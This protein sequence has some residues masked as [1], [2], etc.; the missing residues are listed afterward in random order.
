MIKQLV[1]NLERLN[2]KYEREDKL[3]RTV[4][5]LFSQEGNSYSITI[6]QNNTV[7][8]NAIVGSV[9]TTLN[10]EFVSLQSWMPY[11]EKPYISI[12]VAHSTANIATSEICAE[13]LVHGN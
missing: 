2:L 8:V 7:E 13:D 9:K 11:Y 4:F 6:Y 10:G 1:D 5:K 3:H 12:A